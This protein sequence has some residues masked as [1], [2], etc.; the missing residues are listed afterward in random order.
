MAYES[1]HRL[2]TG[3]S[4]NLLTNANL[5]GDGAITY[6]SL[7]DQSDVDYF[8]VT[9]DG[10][11]LITLT[12]ATTIPSSTK[13]WNMSLLDSAG[14]DYLISP[15][16]TLSVIPLINGANQSDN[17]LDVDGLTVLPAAGSRFTIATAGADTSIYTVISA[18]ALTNGIS[19]LT[20][21]KAV[22]SPADNAQ[23]IFDPVSTTTGSTTTLKALVD[24]AG[25]YYVK[26]AK[27][28]AASAQEYSVTATVTPTEEHDDLGNDTKSEALLSGNR[29][30][31]GV[32]M[33]GNLDTATDNDVWLFTAVN[34]T[35]V[36][37]TFAAP[38]G[39]TLSNDWTISITDWSGTQV[40]TSGGTPL[41]PFSAGTAASASFTTTANTTYLVTVIPAKSPPSESN[42]TLKISGASLDLNDS[43]FMT[44]GAVSSSAPNEVVNTGV[45]KNIQASA[46]SSLL[47]SSLFTASDADTGQALSYI[48]TLEKPTGSTSSGYFKVG[49]TSYGLVDGMT[50][51]TNVV[52]SAAQ[53]ASAQFFAGTTTGDIILT[54]QARDNSAANDGSDY[55]ARMKQTLRTVDKG[56][57]A[58]S[59]TATALQEGSSSS[60]DTITVKLDNAP[61]SGETV[62][63][64]LGHGSE[65]ST[66]HEL[67]YA[68]TGGSAVSSLTFNS[69]N[70]NTA[71]SV[72]V[73]AREDGVLEG[74]H[75]GVL[76]FNVVSSNP[77]SSYNGLVISA[78]TY[79]INDV[80]N[81]PASG[82]VTLSGT[83]TQNQTITATPSI[84]DADGLGTL[85]YTW[86]QSSDGTTWATIAGSGIGTTHVLTNDQVGK[87]VRAVAQYTDGKGQAESVTSSASSSKVEN[88]NDAPTVANA[89]ADQTA[90]AGSSFSYTVPS[91]AFNDVDS[92]DTLTYAATLADNSALPLWISFNP[93]T[94][95]FTHT[96]EGVSASSGTSIDVK[97]TAT[98]NATSP[99]SVSDTFK[100]TVSTA[101]GAPRVATLF[102]DQA[103]TEEQTFTYT[104]PSGSFTDTDNTNGT[105]DTSAALSYIAK[106]SNGNDLPDWLQFSVANGTLSFSGTPGNGDVG[107]LSVKVTATDVGSQKISDTFDI[108]VAN[109]NDAPTLVTPATATFTDTAAT[110]TLT[111]LNTGATNR[112]G[113]LVGSDD[114]SGDTLSYSIDGVTENSG[115]YIKSGTHATLQVIKATGAYTLTPNADA[116]NSLGYHASETFTVTVSDGHGGT[117]SKTLT[118]N[119]TAADDTGGVNDLP[120][121]TAINT[122]TGAKEDQAFTISYQ[123]LADAANEADIDGQ[124]LSFQ[125]EAVSSGT[126]LK[127]GEQ[128]VAKGD[129]LS[130]SD[131]VSLHWTPAKDATGVLDAFTVKAVDSA[132]G[133]SA[134]PVQ[135][136]VNVEPEGYN[137]SGTVKFWKGSAGIEGVKTSFAS[138]FID[139]DSNG[140]FTLPKLLGSNNVELQKTVDD[141]INDAITP[142]DALFALKLFV[143]SN[144]NDGGAPI[145]PYQYLA[146]DVSSDGIIDPTDALYILQMFVGLSSAPTK[147]WIFQDAS[148][149]LDSMDSDHVVTPSTQWP[150]TLDTP[151]LMQLIGIVKGDVDG[152]WTAS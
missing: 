85:Q 120:T 18:S 54:L 116:I 137:L 61:A 64:Y 82:P 129:T 53:I 93:T 103:A 40:R 39:T 112:T 69:T 35:P 135:V 131:I 50:A 119:I 99:L 133:E 128:T 78:L 117:A 21:D 77:T 136:K 126:T 70:Y 48:V 3:V 113:T 7:S 89:I 9:A 124:T 41:A 114:D 20:L 74:S 118:V 56:V 92:G 73:T 142:T 2:S 109:V 127:K 96:G 17:T 143:G 67:S 45:V 111:S 107:T 57:T 134:S 138:N 100:I 51:P 63:V 24:S 46:T 36:T 10:P 68:T 110:D 102:G 5:L 26:V 59:S 151:K 60:K 25:T 12:F 75:S 87:Y 90:F 105:T 43:P 80:A 47:L 30:L 37:L 86:Q 8:K 19:T 141:H 139:T 148:V 106:L 115:T 72:V 146:A 98:D 32:A 122:L 145:S 91:N 29:M 49:S 22:A 95:T 14:A 150:I 101:T 104:V 84:T 88:I 55:G 121:L 144:P 42:Y 27:G 31:N 83:Y 149:N 97:V 147:G 123:T 62:T 79:T 125:V 108:V 38:S 140:A 130:A 66:E 52:L 44:V 16:R 13:Y 58:T 4:N 1:E 71:Q 6:A 152:D 15:T 11:G 33:T 94:R 76:S 34:A 132:G 65:V 81:S 28:D 23:L